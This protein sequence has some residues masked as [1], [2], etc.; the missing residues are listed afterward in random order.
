[1]KTIQDVENEIK[2]IVEIWADRPIYVLS[3]SDKKLRKAATSNVRFLK[4]CKAY[5]LT[6]PTE[7][8]LRKQLEKA[9][10]SVFEIESR[11][12][13]IVRVPIGPERSALKRRFYAIEGMKTKRDQLKMILFLINDPV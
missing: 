13:E 9:K 11:F 2:A 1:M 6:N 7:A 5:L 12:A 8:F 10:R 4:N 3:R